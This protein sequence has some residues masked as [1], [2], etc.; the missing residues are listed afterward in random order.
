H[1]SGDRIRTISLLAILAEVDGRKLY[2]AEG[3]SS[4]IAFCTGQ[5]HMSEDEAYKR[6]AVARSTRR[7]P[8]LAAALAQNRLHLTG[9]SLL[10]PHLTQDNAHELIAAAAHRSKAQIVILLAGRF[11]QPDLAPRITPL[12]PSPSA[13]ASGLFAPSASTPSAACGAANC[14]D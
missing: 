3:Y 14:P 5:H 7:F 10:A 12:G 4:M 6:I 2:L 13:S 8:E 11:P 9:A 1:L